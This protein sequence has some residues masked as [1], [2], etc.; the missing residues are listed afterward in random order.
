MSTLVTIAEGRHLRLVRRG[1][2]EFV[3]RMKGTG[4]VA[5]VALT[6]DGRLVLVEQFRAPLERSVIEL[7][8][9][10]AGDRHGIEDESLEAAARR[11]LLEETGYEAGAMEAV[12]TAATSAGITNEEIVFFVAGGVRRVGPGGGDETEDITVHTVPLP[13]LL[14]WTRRMQRE[15]GVGVDAKVFTGAMLLGAR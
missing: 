14:A 8:A 9:G 7:P 3:D 1:T 11:E 12:L 10:V 2:W 13:D 5:I 4:V 15:R 6:D